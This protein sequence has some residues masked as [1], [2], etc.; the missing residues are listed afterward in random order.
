VG[1]RSDLSWPDLFT[2]NGSYPV[3][4]TAAGTVVS[5]A[6]SAG[7]AGAVLRWAWKD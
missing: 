5:R 7:V 1:T 6:E 2:S 4:P 3:L